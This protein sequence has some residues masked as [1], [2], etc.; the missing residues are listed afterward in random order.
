[1]GVEGVK[2]QMNVER[3]NWLSWVFQDNLGM[4][5]ELFALGK[6]RVTCGKVHVDSYLFVPIDITLDGLG[7]G[8]IPQTFLSRLLYPEGGTHGGPPCR[9]PPGF[10]FESNLER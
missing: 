8:G 5:M 2:Y 10:I 1:M 7:F 6:V 9:W 4:K 3:L